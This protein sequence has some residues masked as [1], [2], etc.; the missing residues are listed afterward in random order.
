VLLGFLNVTSQVRAASVNFIEP[1][2]PVVEYGRSVTFRG[3]LLKTVKMSQL[4]LKYKISN[5]QNE[6]AITNVVQPVNSEQPMSE[7]GNQGDIIE[8]KQVLEPNGSV[9]LSLYWRWWLIEGDK[10]L[11]A[12]IVYDDTIKDKRKEWYITNSDKSNIHLFMS[13]KNQDVANDVMASLEDRLL[14]LERSGFVRLDSMS[15]LYNWNLRRNNGGNTDKI[16]FDI[17]RARLPLDIF[18]YENSEMFPNDKDSNGISVGFSS[19]EWNAKNEIRAELIRKFTVHVLSL[20]KI[21]CRA[22][23][24]WFVEGF[25]THVETILFPGMAWNGDGQEYLA[26]I[27]QHGVLEVGGMGTTIKEKKMQ[28][29]QGL[30]IVDFL[31]NKYGE[32]KL[33]QLWKI[34]ALH[35]RSNYVDRSAVGSLTHPINKIGPI[36]TIDTFRQEFERVYGFP[37]ANLGST[38]TDYLNQTYPEETLIPPYGEPAIVSEEHSTQQSWEFISAPLNVRFQ[39][40]AKDIILSMNTYVGILLFCVILVITIMSLARWYRNNS[41]QE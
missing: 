1:L 15:P 29:I 41:Q 31:R 38:Y 6:C 16:Y 5:D 39:L 32:E 21:I 22:T 28:K 30:F 25:T 35:G 27:R 2:P 40:N 23:P 11:T 37:Y 3:K 24:D 8:Y 36:H 26:Y 9:G 10:S 14:L 17:N 12:S 18:V 20:D 4:S 7:I 13:Y 34:Q 19:N 33:G